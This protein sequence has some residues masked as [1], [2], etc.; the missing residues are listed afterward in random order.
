MKHD[1]VLACVCMT[2]TLLPRLLRFIPPAAKHARLNFTP[3][4]A[5]CWPWFFYDALIEQCS[6]TNIVR[7]VY[8]TVATNLQFQRGETPLS[9][10]AQFGHEACNRRCNAC[11]CNTS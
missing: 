3:S 4:I 7:N 1:Q 2:T 5:Y 9:T 10:R 11:A 6:F 8:A